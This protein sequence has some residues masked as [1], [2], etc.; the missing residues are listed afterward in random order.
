MVPMEDNGICDISVSPQRGTTFQHLKAFVTER[1]KRSEPC[2]FAQANRTSSYK[3]T[4]SSN[5]Q[6]PQTRVPKKEIQRRI[7]SKKEASSYQLG[8]QLSLNW[9]TGAGPRIGCVS[10]YPMELRVQALDSVNLAPMVN[11]AESET[12]HSSMVASFSLC[13][14]M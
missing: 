10:D 6:S 2:G 4:F 8:K 14:I 1:D 5:L 11:L 12:E 3:R 7:K 9:S 13:R